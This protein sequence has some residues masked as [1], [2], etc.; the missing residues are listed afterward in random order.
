M[1][2]ASLVCL[3]SFFVALNAQTTI[4]NAV[5]PLVGDTLS[6][7]VDENPSQI[8]IGMQGGDQQ[9]DFSSLQ[10]AFGFQQI[11][12]DEMDGVGSIF[13]P[14]ASLFY[15][16]TDS[17]ETYLSVSNDKIE[18]LGVFGQD[19][20]GLG[21]NLNSIFDPPIVDRRAP[22]NFF[23]VNT[24]DASLLL[25]ISADDLPDTIVNALP[26]R[27]DSLRIRIAIDR[28]DVVDAWG[29]LSLP[30]ENF[31]VLREKRVETR[32]TRLDA[33]VGF[34]GW[35]DVTDIAI[36]FL[37]IPAIGIDTSISYHY[38]SNDSKET[39]AICF[40][41]NSEDVIQRVQFKS[42]EIVTGIDDFEIIGSTLKVYPNPANKSINIDVTEL[43]LGDFKLRIFN[44]IGEKVFED[45]AA[46]RK[47]NQ[48][49]EV[50]VS[51]FSTGTYFIHLT[52][53][54]SKKFVKR[55]LMVTHP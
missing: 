3:L 42:R 21:L 22:M 44:S 55:K 30:G 16:L 2:E 32:E 18:L 27:P 9:W 36:Q 8:S 29:N 1:K 48:I 7:S 24:M 12:K 13:F 23:D 47:N 20:I 35:Q 34:L 46:T 33:K 38:F 49:I 26:I 37:G 25:A 10:S 5:F 40:M 17:V 11:M 6:Y 51:K 39:V 14:G 31:E 52:D 4:T 19:P 41:N 28:L 53:P 50:D 43:D 45:P 54:I 15:N